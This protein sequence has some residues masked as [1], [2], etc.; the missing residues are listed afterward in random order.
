MVNLAQLIKVDREK[1]VNC[2]ACISACPVKFCNDSSDDYVD[3]NPNLCIGCGNCL[4]ACS[5]GARTGMDDFDDFI[6]DIGN[7]EKFVAIVAPATAASFPGEY[8]KLN[9]WLSSLGVKAFFDV[10]FGAELTVKSYENHIKNNNP[11][12]VI[13]QPCPAIVNYIQLYK[14]S[15]IKYLAPADS[16]MLH[17]I[18][19]IHKYYPQYKKHKI[20]AVS[21]CYAKK[22]EFAET[23]YA[24]TVYNVTTI[25]IDNYMEEADICLSE[26]EDVDFENPD[27]ERAVMF[28]TPGGLLETAEREVPGIREKTRKIEGVNFVYKYLDGLEEALSLKSNPLLVD[29][30]NCE[31]GCNGGTGTNNKFLNHDYLEMLITERKNKMKEKYKP[32]FFLKARGKLRNIISSYWHESDYRRSYRDLSDNIDFREPD[33]SELETVYKLMHKYSDD[34]IYNCSACGYNECKNMG[35]AIFNNLNKPENCHYYKNH[36]I[37]IE[38]EKADRSLNLVN[39]ALSEIEESNVSAMMEK[40]LTF[41]SEQLESLMELAGEMENSIETAHKFMPIVKAIS[42]IS[43]QTKL[44]A[45]NASIEAA[46]AGEIGNGFS[47]VANEVKKLAKR[48][49]D[50]VNKIVPYSTQLQTLFQELTLKTKNMAQN[51]SKVTTIGKGVQESNEK[52]AQVKD[53]L[54]KE[55]E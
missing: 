54:R 27:A 32:G 17:T 23:G 31:M 18:K 48:T 4:T 13:A 25:S 40:L 12:M 30:L 55:V 6:R 22:R 20:L 46:H 52:I 8:L 50:E 14:P 39:A 2:H 35:Y 36:Q 29:C 7:G 9:G 49:Q 38:H 37:K 11:E 28:S 24:D 47:V 3:V 26:Y 5:H 43:L 15:L 34:D 21:P 44:L 41:T 33:P 16:P 42:D 10:S 53:L 51:Y 45:M 19:M 1:C